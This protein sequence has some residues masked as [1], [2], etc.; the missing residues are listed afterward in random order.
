MQR[1]MRL[2]PKNHALIE[3]EEETRNC[4]DMDEGDGLEEREDF[5]SKRIVY[6]IPADEHRRHPLVLGKYAISV[7]VQFL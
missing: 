3:K 2:N 7:S 1:R 6:A 5:R 4:K